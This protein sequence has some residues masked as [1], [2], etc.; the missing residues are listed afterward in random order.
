MALF[1]DNRSFVR[2]FFSGLSD[3]DI[4][5]ENVLNGPHRSSI[6]NCIH[7]LCFTE[8]ILIMSLFRVHSNYQI[9]AL[10]IYNNNNQ[11]DN[12]VIE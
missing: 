10:A 1:V 2:S 7:T 11:F 9:L 5:S 12:A 3:L 8:T 6:E 4:T